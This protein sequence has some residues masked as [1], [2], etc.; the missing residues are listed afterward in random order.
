MTVFSEILIYI[1]DTVGLLFLLFVILRFLLQ[2][3]RA[4]FY[5]PI[6]QATQKITNPLLMPIRKIIPGLFGIDL[7]SIILAVLVQI[8]VGMLIGFI[9][10]QQILNPLQV[11]FAG[12]L[13][14]LVITSYIGIGCILILVVSSFVAPYSSHPIIMLVRQLTEPL[15]APIRKIIPPIGGLDFSVMALGM[16]IYIAQMLIYAAA[17]SLAL[18]FKVVLG[19]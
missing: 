15:L 5:N 3:A 6:S 16:G 14:I 1:V 8:A 7:A 11:A 18:P 10:V 4:D 19:F 17:G 13:G 9:L 12:I 2:L